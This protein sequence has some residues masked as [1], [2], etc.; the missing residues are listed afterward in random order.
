[1]FSNMYATQNNVCQVGFAFL[2]VE[3]NRSV[4]FHE[5]IVTTLTGKYQLH[6][7]NN[8]RTF[9]RGIRKEIV[10]HDRNSMALKLLVGN[11]IDFNRYMTVLETIEPERSQG[12]KFHEVQKV[13][14]FFYAY[15]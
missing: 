14:D 12:N 7:V 4:F 10:E 5:T 1:M 3:I 2:N 11:E 6:F 8:G 15:R 9:V 13:M